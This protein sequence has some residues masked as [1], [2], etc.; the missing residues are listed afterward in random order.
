[1]LNIVDGVTRECLRAVARATAE[2]RPSAE[3]YPPARI[4]ERAE[5]QSRL[6]WSQASTPNNTKPA[7]MNLKPLAEFLPDQ[8]VQL[9]CTKP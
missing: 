1:M 8:P 5:C 2:R 7:P 9:R 6:K 3:G 4:Q